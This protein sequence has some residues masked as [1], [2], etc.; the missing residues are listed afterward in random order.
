MKPILLLPF[1]AST[2][3]AGPIETK[4]L[5]RNPP[6]PIVSVPAT[7]PI[8]SLP[9]NQ[10]FVYQQQAIGGRAPLVSPEQARAVI[11]RFK[12]GYPKLS[13]PRLLVY[14]NRELIDDSSGLR[15]VG[16]SEKTDQLK[17][18]L[19]PTGNPAQGPLGQNVT[20]VGNPSLDSSGNPVRGTSERVTGDNTYAHR[21]RSPTPLS[22]RQTIR[23]VERLMGRP[24]RLGGAR[25]TDQR[26]AT[27]ILADRSVQEFLGTTGTAVAA[28]D[29]EALL[30]SADVVVEVLISSRS[31]PV[32][33]VSGD[34]VFEV[35]DI[36]ATAIRLTDSQILGQ[37]SSAD[38]LGPDRL[39][40]RI[41]RNYDV[42]EITEAVALALM[43]DMMQGIQ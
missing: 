9:A 42:R 38:I 33:G 3:C 17:A 7:S 14:V 23:D 13:A 29:R 32:P 40:G 31:L 36:Q 30:R 35:P 39:A 34:Q 20:I 21:D 18:D 1:L 12:A 26:I 6:P 28:K 11:D 16:R 27:Q 15:I 5:P 10:P 2:L 37:A 8:E 43:E 41:A 19:T 25:L 4:K 24:L 22:D